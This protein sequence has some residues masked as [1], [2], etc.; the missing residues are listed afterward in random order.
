MNISHD[1]YEIHIRGPVSTRATI[2]IHKCLQ[3][4]LSEMHRKLSEGLLI[5]RIGDLAKSDKDEMAPKV[6]GLLKVLDL[7]NIAYNIYELSSTYLD[8]EAPLR[9]AEEVSK[10]CLVRQI[11]AYVPSIVDEILSQDDRDT[12]PEMERAWVDDL[13][14]STKDSDGTRYLHGP[15]S[16][17]MTDELRGLRL[18]KFS[19]EDGLIKADFT[20]SQFTELLLANSIVCNTLERTTWKNCSFTSVTFDVTNMRATTFIDCTFHNVEF[21]GLYFYQ[22]MFQKCTFQN[23]S[24]K[25]CRVAH[26]VQRNLV[27]DQLIDEIGLSKQSQSA[28]FR[29]SKVP[30]ALFSSCS[31]NNLSFEN[32]LFRGMRFSECDVKDVRASNV[33]LEGIEGDGDWWKKFEESDCYIDYLERAIAILERDDGHTKA[34]SL[35][36]THLST[37][38][39]KRARRKAYAAILLDGGISLNEKESMEFLLYRELRHY[40]F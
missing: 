10:D 27:N 36:K 17:T 26:H 38:R 33:E 16:L 28:L 21:L 29:W 2:D 23:I 4:P 37:Y 30:H 35:L 5:L 14:S 40:P 3:K 19:I 11:R 39:E 32:V 12:H 20:A 9:D 18:N 25:G 22:T 34:L 31:F 8:D 15:T 13:Q 24:F 6:L 7:H 1:G